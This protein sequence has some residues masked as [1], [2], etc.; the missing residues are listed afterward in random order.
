M[1]FD[2]DRLEQVK[3]FGWATSE[4][5]SIISKEGFLLTFDALGSSKA[6]STFI[7]PQFDEK[8]PHRHFMFHK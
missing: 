5:I 4:K 7:I 6:F 2:E 1:N 3:R 8:A